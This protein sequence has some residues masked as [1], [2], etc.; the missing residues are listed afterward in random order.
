MDRFIN[1]LLDTYKKEIQYYRD[2]LNNNKKLINK[3]KNDKEVID[4]IDILSWI[5][6]IDKDDGGFKNIMETRSRSYKS[7]FN[8][9]FNEKTKILRKERKYFLKKMKELN[10]TKK[11]EKKIEKKIKKNYFCVNDKDYLLLDDVDE[12]EKE[13][14]VKFYLNKKIHCMDKYS[15]ISLFNKKLIYKAYQNDKE[16]RLFKIPLNFTIFIKEKHAEK[17][18]LALKKNKRD[19]KINDNNKKFKQGL[20][21]IKLYDIEIQK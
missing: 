13:N 11:I 17:I 1:N 10:K 21:Y 5:Y 4:D 14:L 9:I 8:F 20:Q 3:L 18:L 19:F 7:A 16:I 2:I 15:I 12:I 6:L